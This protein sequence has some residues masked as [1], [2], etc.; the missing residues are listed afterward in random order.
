MKI[1]IAG[2]SGAIGSHLV[3]Q[4]VARGHQVVGT[5]RSAAK[6]GVL[7]ALGAEPV[8]SVSSPMVTWLQAAFLETR[9][10]EPVCCVG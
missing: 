2:A 4:L 3:P 6:T 5:T 10:A 1:F 8:A 7:R 9:L